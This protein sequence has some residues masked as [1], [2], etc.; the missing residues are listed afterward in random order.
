MNTFK[1]ILIIILLLLWI[2]G[3]AYSIYYIINL[4]IDIDKEDKKI[5]KERV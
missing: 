2:A 1:N 3:A 4:N 5:I